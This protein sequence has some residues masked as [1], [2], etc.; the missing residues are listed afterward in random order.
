MPDLYKMCHQ[1]SV[2]LVAL[3]LLF[4]EGRSLHVFSVYSPP[5][6]S[7]NY[8]DAGFWSSF[9]QICSRFQPAVV[10]GNFN[11]KSPLW[12]DTLSSVNVEK[13]K[14][15]NAIVNF[16]LFVLNDE[17]YTWCLSDL[18]RRFSLD[19]TV[20]TQ[21]IAAQCSWRVCDFHYGNDH[22]P[23]VTI[24]RNRFSGRTA[25]RLYYSVGKVNWDILNL[26]ACP[27][28]PVSLNLLLDDSDVHLVYTSLVKL[29]ENALLQAGASKINK[30]NTSRKPPSLW[31]DASSSEE[32]KKKKMTFDQYRAW[33]SSKNLDNYYKVAKEVSRFLRRKKRAAFR[34]FCGSLYANSDV[35]SIWNTVKAF[36][37]AR[38]KSRYAGNRNC[39]DRDGFSQ[40]LDSSV[41]SSYPPFPIVRRC[42][43]SW[44]VLTRS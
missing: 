20:V 41:E 44:K 9:F 14:I 16:P 5:R 3:Q 18:S 31:W 8:T 21:N 13:K 17:S 22:F 10:C 1:N 7:S 35:G 11:E 36:T 33:P 28:S 29:I 40:A 34:K 38:S 19:L 15:E 24:V 39:L 6:C 27:K 30:L 23:V 12:C 43:R 2:K 25:C 4:P 37:G 32:Y 26:S 42:S